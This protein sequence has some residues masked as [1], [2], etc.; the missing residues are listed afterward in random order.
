MILL[1]SVEYT[2]KVPQILSI[3]HHSN[4]TPP[5]PPRNYNPHYGIIIVMGEGAISYLTNKVG[6]GL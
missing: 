3:A 1:L 5:P 4:P 6:E 2:K